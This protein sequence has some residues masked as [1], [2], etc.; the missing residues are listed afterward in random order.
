MVGAITPSFNAMMQASNSTAPVPP[1]MW[2]CI[3]LVEDTRSCPV[4]APN[5]EW[6]AAHSVRSFAAVPVPWALM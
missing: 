2:P 6:I 5:A 1:M 3:A 4:A